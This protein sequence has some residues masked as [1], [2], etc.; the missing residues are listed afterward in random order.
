MLKLESIFGKSKKEISEAP[1]LVSPDFTKDFS[2]F[3]YASEYTIA[4]VLLQK[5]DENLE[6]PIAFFS[7]MLRDGELKYDIMEKQAYAL[8]KAL[9]DF[10]VYI[11]HSHIIAHVPSAAV[12]GILTQPDPKGRR[13]KWIATLLEYDIKIKPTKLIKGQGLAKMMANSNCEALQINFLSHQANQLDTEVEV[14]V[15]FV[16][17]HGI[18]IL[19]MSFEICKHRRG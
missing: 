7:K 17:L 15:D 16:L 2:V 6:Q 10:R 11:L 14:M 8:V 19:Y 1:V 18:L 12:K 3:S 9:K 13:A 4:A 5:N